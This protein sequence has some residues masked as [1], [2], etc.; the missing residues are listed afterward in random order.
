M[1]GTAAPLL[2]RKDTPPARVGHACEEHQRR[3]AEL[4]DRDQRRSRDEPGETP[5]AGAAKHCWVI[6]DPRWPNRH[7]GLLL[8][9][10]RP[11]G[12]WVGRVV[13]VPTVGYELIV[14]LVPAGHLRAEEP[15][16]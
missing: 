1:D 9:W 4:R 15:N 8:S 12:G 2:P 5:G 16:R 13:L 14:A 7:P 6:D 10:E 3:L 11:V